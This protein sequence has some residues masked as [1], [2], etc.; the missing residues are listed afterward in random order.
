M[1][2]KTMLDEYEVAVCDQDDFMVNKEAR[3][4]AKRTVIT[5]RARILELMEKGQRYEGLEK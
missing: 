4:E 5:H 3:A 2:P 1:D